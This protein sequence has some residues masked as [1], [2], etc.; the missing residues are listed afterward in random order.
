MTLKLLGQMTSQ[1]PLLTFSVCNLLL[2]RQSRAASSNKAWSRNVKLAIENTTVTGRPHLSFDNPICLQIYVY[3]SIRALSCGQRVM[4]WIEGDAHRII[5]VLLVFGHLKGC[6]T[7][8]HRPAIKP[9]FEASSTFA[10]WTW[11]AAPCIVYNK[12]C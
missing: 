8:M 2:M 11:W 4:M 7:E 1:Q 6:Y 12:I 5:N 3:S 9:K 10:E